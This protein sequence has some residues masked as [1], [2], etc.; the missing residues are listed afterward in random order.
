M[1]KFCRSSHVPTSDRF[2][3]LNRK[4]LAFLVIA[5]KYFEQE[6]LSG[7]PYFYLRV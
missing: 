3:C 2:C 1:L 4:Q 5:I 7:A 6:T